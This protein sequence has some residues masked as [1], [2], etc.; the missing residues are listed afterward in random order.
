L[1]AGRHILGVL[2]EVFQ[3]LLGRAFMVYEVFEAHGRSG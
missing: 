3:G 1:A 2:L